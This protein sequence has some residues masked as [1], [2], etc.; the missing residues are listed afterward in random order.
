[1]QAREMPMAVPVVP[2][3]QRRP[4][5]RP[6]GLWRAGSEEK[7]IAEVTDMVSH[8]ARGQGLL[9]CRE[10]PKC[11]GGS[12]AFAQLARCPGRARASSA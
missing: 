3:R 1:M 4:A 6:T 7:Q 10:T 9:I 2:Q 5:P 8:H 11:E 12:A